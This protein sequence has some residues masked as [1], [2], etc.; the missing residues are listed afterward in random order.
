MTCR[1]KG[2]DRVMKYKLSERKWLTRAQKASE[3]QASDCAEDTLCNLDSQTAVH[4]GDQMHAIAC[5]CSRE[6]FRSSRSPACLRWRSVC[7]A[8]G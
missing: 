3:H 5:F 6:A 7:C 4:I 8:L 1:R 2:L